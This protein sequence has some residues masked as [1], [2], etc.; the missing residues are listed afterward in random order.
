MPK[1][2]QG[3]HIQDQYFGSGRCIYTKGNDALVE[4]AKA[5]PGQL[6]PGI[7]SITCRITRGYNKEGK[8]IRQRDYGSFGAD[9][10]CRWYDRSKSTLEIVLYPDKIK[11]FQHAPKGMV[12]QTVSGQ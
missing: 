12:S 7:W 4:F 8:R 1:I 5:A 2:N 3:D 6:L 9:D 10:R 11:K